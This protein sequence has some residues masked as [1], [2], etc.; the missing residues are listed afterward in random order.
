MT[1][2]LPLIP[3]NAGTHFVRRRPVR[4]GLKQVV[5]APSADIEITRM[6]PGIRRDER[7]LV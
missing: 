3:A 5:L 4:L 7:E 1:L 6:G 2:P